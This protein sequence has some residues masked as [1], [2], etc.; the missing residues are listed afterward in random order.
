MPRT[1]SGKLVGKTELAEIIGVSLPTIDHWLAKG[2]P[3]VEQG[4]RGVSY[5]FN[6]SDCIDWKFDQIR[7]EY[8]NPEK[9]T[10]I[11]EY[12]EARRMRMQAD[13]ELAE[14]NLHRERGTVVSIEVIEEQLANIL[15]TV[16][17]QSGA[18]P[19]KLAHRFQNMRSPKKIENLMRA[20][21]NAALTDLSIYDPKGLPKD[22]DDI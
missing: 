9:D 17:A 8:E 22:L 5:V 2:M 21:L 16:K 1:Y 4:G 20:E 19:H 15:G 12:S 18:I 14:L 11:I 6:T 7:A 10:N 3:F 13:A